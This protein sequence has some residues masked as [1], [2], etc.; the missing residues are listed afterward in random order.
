MLH[1]RRPG[2]IHAH[3]TSRF[4]IGLSLAVFHACQELPPYVKRVEPI[5]TQHLLTRQPFYQLEPVC[6]IPFATR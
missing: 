3:T 6:L 4:D 1:A 2:T 5:A